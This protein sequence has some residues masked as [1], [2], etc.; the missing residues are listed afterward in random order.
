MD[1]KKKGCHHEKQKEA[2]LM[3]FQNVCNNYE[4]QL[5]LLS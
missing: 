5:Y 2:L 4:G 3:L 1:Q